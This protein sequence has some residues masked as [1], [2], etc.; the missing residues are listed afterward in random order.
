[1]KDDSSFQVGFTLPISQSLATGLLFTVAA[2]G[3]SLSFHW[4]VSWAFVGGG[5][6]AFITWM[7]LIARML[8]VIE[9][10]L[11]QDLNG[12]GVIGTPLPQF[13][14][15]PPPTT[16]VELIKTDQDHNVV[17]GEY[18]DLPATPEQL[19]L[20]AEGNSLTVNGWSGPGKPFTRSQFETL[21]DELLHRGLAAPLSDKSK[22]S[23]FA[24]TVVG[25][26]ILTKVS[27]TTPPPHN[28]LHKPM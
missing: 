25:K 10:V 19:G 9:Y 28:H 12:D 6:V 20:L 13:P 24:L 23:G 15:L 17:E 21:R 18:L 11:K 7:N 26:H 22:K 16:R 5:V 2:A 4:P 27:K 1:M 14:Q 3:V 8:K